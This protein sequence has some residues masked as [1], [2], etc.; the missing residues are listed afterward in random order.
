MLSGVQD[1][2]ASSTSLCAICSGVPLPLRTRRRGGDLDRPGAQR[3]QWRELDVEDPP[4]A[5][6]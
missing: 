3:R 1:R 6:R 5:Y 2:S 4:G